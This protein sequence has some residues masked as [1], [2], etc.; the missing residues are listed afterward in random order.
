MSKECPR[1]PNVEY[2]WRMPLTAFCWR[3][4][5]WLLKHGPALRW[6]TREG[7]ARAIASAMGAYRPD[8]RPGFRIHEFVTD[9]SP[10]SITDSSNEHHVINWRVRG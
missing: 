9:D 4:A 8:V 7:Q 1:F 2:S 5:W 3:L 10:V 6:M